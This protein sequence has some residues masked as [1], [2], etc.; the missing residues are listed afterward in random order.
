[1][2]IVYFG[3]DLFYDCFEALVKDGHD[4]VKIFTCP[5]DGEY[6][7]NTRIYAAARRLG[8]DIT[9]KK[10]GRCEL[11]KLVDDGC[12]LMISAGYYYKIPVIGGVMQVN[13]HPAL[14]P[15]GRGPWPQ[16]VAILKAMKKFGVTLH[17]LADGFDSGDIVLQQSFDVS[18]NENLETLTEK[19]VLHAVS[20][21]R[22]F[23]RKPLYYWSYAVSQ[24]SGEYWREPTEEEMTFRPCD[25]FEKIDR[26]TRAFYGYR[27]FMLC[28]G[29]KTVIKRAKCIKNSQTGA[30]SSQFVIDIEGG[31]LIILNL[32]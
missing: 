8:I 26:I 14:L 7:F 24:P 9:D 11:T 16:P 15:V 22:K 2:K 25:G 20:A 12:E 6:E 29:V 3:F 21:L 19:C 1:M 18:K 17:K 4:I 10:P 31:R 5:V 23:M 28:G 30:V 13:I 32:A 27:C